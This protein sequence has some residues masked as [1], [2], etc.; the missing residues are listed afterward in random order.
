MKENIQL[1]SRNTV[2]SSSPMKCINVR[3]DI[4][5]G[6]CLYTS[7]LTVVDLLSYPFMYNACMKEVSSSCMQLFSDLRYPDILLP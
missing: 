6:S 2:T 5:Y 4:S 7:T 1:L 3:P